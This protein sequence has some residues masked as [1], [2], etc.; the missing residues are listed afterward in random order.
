MCHVFRVVFASWSRPNLPSWMALRDADAQTGL[1]IDAAWNMVSFVARV[2]DST[3][4]T[5]HAF[6]QSIVKSRITATLTAGTWKRS[7]SSAS[8][9]GSVPWRPGD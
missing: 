1:L 8:V 9:N 4:A 7:I 5:P 6:A 2:P 3:S